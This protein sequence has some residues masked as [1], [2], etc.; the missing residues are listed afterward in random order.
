VLCCGTAQQCARLSR[1]VVQE[2]QDVFHPVPGSAEPLG[3]VAAGRA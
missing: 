2:V 3:D 1:G